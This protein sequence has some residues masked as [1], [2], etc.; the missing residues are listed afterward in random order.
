MVS[1]RKGTDWL[2]PTLVGVREIQCDVG[3]EASVLTAASAH[4]P[5]TRTP[6]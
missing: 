2:A 3:L 4:Q 5:K 1:L 6:T